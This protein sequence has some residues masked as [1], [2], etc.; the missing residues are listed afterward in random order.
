MFYFD[1]ITLYGTLLAV[2]V[3]GVVSYLSRSRAV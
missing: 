2:Y 1:T 3:A